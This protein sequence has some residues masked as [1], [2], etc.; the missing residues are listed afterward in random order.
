MAGNRLRGAFEG[1]RGDTPEG[2][3]AILAMVLWKLIWVP[4]A[5]VA[6]VLA[7]ELYDRV[8]FALTAERHSGEVVQRFSAEGDG[9]FDRGQTQY[10]V[11]V[12]FTDDAGIERVTTPGLRHPALD[13]APGETVEVLWRFSPDRGG[14]ME[15]GALSLRWLYWVPL[16]VVAGL[17]LVLAPPTVYLHRRIRPWVE[18]RLDAL[19][20]RIAT[21]E[22]GS[23]P[24]P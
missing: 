16:L 23:P 1:M 13:F 2:R 7:W 5:A 21:E 15:M 20:A 10:W 18:R 4:L 17:G 12:R 9:P 11:Q 8:M 14:S 22:G 24:Q 6:I 3:R 19:E